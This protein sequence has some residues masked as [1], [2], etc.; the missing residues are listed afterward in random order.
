MTGPYSHGAR[1]RPFQS[2]I[3]NI[4]RL[5]CSIATFRDVH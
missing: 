3:L 5:E 4:A 2:F 1:T